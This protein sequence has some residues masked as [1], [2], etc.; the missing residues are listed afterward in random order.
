MN[1][2]SFIE[3]SIMI[4]MTESKLH[5]RNTYTDTIPVSDQSIPHTM[6][7]EE[8]FKEL[9][10]PPKKSSKELARQFM[11][12]ALCLITMVAIVYPI[13]IIPGT[14][15]IIL[16]IEIALVDRIYGE[17]MQARKLVSYTSENLVLNDTIDDS[18]EK[19]HIRVSAYSKRSPN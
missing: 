14:M 4:S 19:N 7:E 17:I 18:I 9:E 8:V 6:D 2:Y 16:P 11:N 13:L 10:T 1:R 3:N 5:F 15:I 12:T